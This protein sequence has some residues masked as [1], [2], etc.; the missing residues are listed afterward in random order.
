MPQEWT[1]EVVAQLHLHKLTIKQL[2][3]EA[4]Y[5]ETTFPHQAP[6]SL[7]TMTCDDYA[8]ALNAAFYD[9]FLTATLENKEEADAVGMVERIWAAAM[10]IEKSAMLCG[11]PDPKPF[12][13][14]EKI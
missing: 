12:E 8:K 9:G 3:E 6:N 1:A 4:G 14:L 7:I 2:A 5:A 10:A 13:A 11:A